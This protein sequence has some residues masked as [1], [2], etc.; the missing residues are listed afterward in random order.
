MYYVTILQNYHLFL[1]TKIEIIVASFCNPLDNYQNDLYHCSVPSTSDS[2]ENSI[3][4]YTTSFICECRCRTMRPVKIVVY[5]NRKPFKTIY[6]WLTW[7]IWIGNRIDFKALTKEMVAINRCTVSTR[8]NNKFRHVY[9]TYC[10]IFALPTSFLCCVCW[11][12]AEAE[13]AEIFVHVV[14]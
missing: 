7:I 1:L 10:A 9:R 13:V 11:T 2:N 5:F 8:R 3:A 6:I 12:R 14:I 4:S